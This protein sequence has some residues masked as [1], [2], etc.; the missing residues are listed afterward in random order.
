MSPRCLDRFEQRIDD[1]RGLIVGITR[2][3]LG[4]QGVGE[5]R[6]VGKVVEV[7][8]VVAVDL[9]G[10][11]AVLHE[12]SFG[13][14]HD[15]RRRVRLHEHPDDGILRHGAMDASVQLLPVVK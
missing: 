14:V 2:Q 10:E 1:G 7:G 11:R 6:V 15:A 13:A 8:E 5:L 3:P 12:A 4:E 9:P